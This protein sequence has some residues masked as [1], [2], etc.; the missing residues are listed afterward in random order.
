VVLPYRKILNS[1]A[2]L[3]ALARNKPVLA[4]RTGSLPE[5][6][7]EVGEEWVRLFDGEIA[8]EHIEAFLAALPLLTAPRPDLSAFEWTKVG[9]DVTQFLHSLRS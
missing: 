8:R 9:A 3:H 6:Q 4:P 2:A 1:G 5:L 7:Q